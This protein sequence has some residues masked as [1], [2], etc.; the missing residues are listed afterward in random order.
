MIALAVAV[1]GTQSLHA[2]CFDEALALLPHEFLVRHRV[3]PLKVDGNVA[4]IGFADAPTPEAAHGPPDKEPEAQEAAAEAPHGSP[5]QQ[6]DPTDDEAEPDPEF[7]QA[8]RADET[9]FDE[10]ASRSE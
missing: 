10:K 5:A 3:L 9:P 4:T 8:V 7:E 2:S 1:G 6:P